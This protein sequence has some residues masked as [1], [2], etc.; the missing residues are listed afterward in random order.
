MEF[1]RSLFRVHER[2]LRGK[3]PK[4]IIWCLEVFFLLLTLFSLTA[5]VMFHQ[6]YVD[7]NDILKPAIE[8]QLKAYFYKNYHSKSGHFP[9]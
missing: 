6:S 1:E 2:I 4:R 9:H 7:K 5:L 3:T 8:E